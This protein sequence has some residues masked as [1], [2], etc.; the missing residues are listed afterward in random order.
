MVQHNSLTVGIARDAKGWFE[1]FEQYG[2]DLG[3]MCEVFDIGRSDW[4]SRVPK[5]ACVVWRPSFEHPWLEQAREKIYFME[6]QLKIRV[7][8]N[9]NTF[10]MYDN[11]KAEAYLLRELEVP[12]P[13]TFVSYCRDECDEYLG[14]CKFPIVSKTSGGAGSSGVRLLRTPADARRE[15]QRVFGGRFRK[16]AFARLGYSTPLRLTR[17]EEYVVWQEFIP[18]NQGD[19]RITIIGGRYGY[20]LYRRNRPGDFRASGSGLL[21]YDGPVGEHEVSFL[22]DVCRKSGFDTMAFDVLFRGSDFVVTEMSYTHPIAFLDKVPGSY[23]VDATGNC[24]YHLGMVPPQQRLMQLVAEFV[25][26][27]EHHSASSR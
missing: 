10:W 14:I 15:V 20:V 2:R 11:K 6:T 3:L 13:E 21:S 23:E 7:F 26:K 25:N 22:A 19:C 16:R 17:P 1:R 4:L 8:P 12:R 18:G 9:W 5:Y 24:H 27:D